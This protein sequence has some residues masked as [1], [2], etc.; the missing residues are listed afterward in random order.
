M[1]VTRRSFLG[2]SGA[3][4]AA[5]AALPGVELALPGSAEAQ[6]TRRARRLLLKDA[7]WL[8]ERKMSAALGP[9]LDAFRARGGVIDRI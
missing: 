7:F 8:E 2:T 9:V 4:I 3:G 1:K 5:T 6:Q